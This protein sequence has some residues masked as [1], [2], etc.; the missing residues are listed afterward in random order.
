MPDTPSAAYVAPPSTLNTWE[1]G[2]GAENVIDPVGALQFEF[3]TVLVGVA[4][5]PVMI[6]VLVAA[7][8]VSE[9]QPVTV[10]RATVL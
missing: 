6:K 9:T 5:A 1:A 7:A 3:A 4:G 2:A 10:L 8:V